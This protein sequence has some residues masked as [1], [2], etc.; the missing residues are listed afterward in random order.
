MKTIS[1]LEINLRKAI[2]DFFIGQYIMLLREIKK[3]VNRWRYLLVVITKGVSAAS[4]GKCK[5]RAPEYA[6]VYRPWKRGQD[7]K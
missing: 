5:G 2:Q 1:C 4:K 6:N 3:D 7:I